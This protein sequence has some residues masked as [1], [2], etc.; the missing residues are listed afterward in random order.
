[1]GNQ[2][3][4]QRHFARVASVYDRFRNTD[5]DVVESIITRLPDVRRP[6]DVA[7]IGCGTGRYSDIIAANLNGNLRLLCC[8]YSGAM[9][10]EC[11]ERMSQDFPSKPF[12][13]C[14]ARADALP[15]AAGSLD[16]VVTFN[17][18]HHFNLDRFVAESARILRP[19]ALLAI[20]TRT[21]QQNLRTIWG[22]HFPGFA[23]RETRLLPQARLDEAIRR[24]PELL[25]EEV[26]EFRHV[27]TESSESLLDRARNFHYSTFALYPPE[28]FAAALATFAGRLSRIGNG[29][30][31][32]VAENT[33]LL[34]RRI[35]ATGFTSD[36]SP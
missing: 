1:M 32:H 22:Q 10:K 36:V 26:R 11:R 31:E 18:I 15:F 30:V 27:R 4:A 12:R 2:Q 25:I 21:P 17:A 3:G 14:L 20:Y 16:G 35:D 33:L 28:E 8:D 19:G 24:R 6:L 7:D 5:P 23:A 29:S 13:Y 34:A 9:L